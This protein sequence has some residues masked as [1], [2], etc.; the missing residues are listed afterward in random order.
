MLSRAESQQD[1]DDPVVGAFL[2]FLANDMAAHPER[3]R[4]V[5]PALLE[6]IHTLT[7]GVEIDLDQPLSPD[8]E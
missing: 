5:D 4:P 2:E 7:Q 3:L 1:G 8:D 6:R